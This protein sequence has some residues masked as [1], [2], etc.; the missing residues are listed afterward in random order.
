[1]MSTA[2]APALKSVEVFKDSVSLFR[3][4]YGAN[5]GPQTFVVV[6]HDGAVLW[7]QRLPEVF[8]RSGEAITLPEIVADKVVV[9]YA[10]GTVDE[11]ICGT[12]L[13]HPVSYKMEAGH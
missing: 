4:D 1:M 10:G 3:C 8:D 13:S 7:G 6:C 2:T 12:A 9:T 5:P 11:L